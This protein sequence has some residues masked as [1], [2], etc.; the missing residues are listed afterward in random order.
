MVCGLACE[1]CCRCV[2][3][4]PPPCACE[5]PAQGYL[6]VL[7]VRLYAFVMRQACKARH[8]LLVAQDLLLL[9]MVIQLHGSQ[10]SLRVG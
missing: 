9:S 5:R 6:L 4:N 2:L 7:G 8:T 3:L 10:R 1:E